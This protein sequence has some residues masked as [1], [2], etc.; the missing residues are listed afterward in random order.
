L[1]FYFRPAT[2]GLGV[3]AGVGFKSYASLQAFRQMSINANKYLKTAGWTRRREDKW[4]LP[5]EQ[6]ERAEIRC[7]AERFFAILICRMPE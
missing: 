5:L 3:H 6:S 2:G 7:W 4:R 1:A